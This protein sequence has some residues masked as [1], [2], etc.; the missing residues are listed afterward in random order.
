MENSTHLNFQ[1]C[2]NILRNNS[3]MDISR[4]L[5]LFQVEIDNINEQSLVNQVEY[6][7]Y[8]DNKTLLDLS[9]CDNTD[10]EIFYSLKDDTYSLS[11][12]NHFKYSNIDIFNINDSFFNDICRPYSVNNNDVVLEDRIKDIYQNYSL[13]DEGCVFKEIDFE[14]KTIICNCNVKNNLSIEEPVLNIIYFDEI[15]IESNFGLIKCYDLVF[16]FNGKS[17]NI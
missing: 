7:I 3:K 12:Y 10:I 9:L 2:E 5:T 14:N 8:D 11:S 13:C 4:I 16:S 6:Q 1:K 15:K 17:K